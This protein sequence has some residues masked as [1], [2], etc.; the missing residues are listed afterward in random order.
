MCPTLGRTLSAS[1]CLAVPAGERRRVVLGGR[2][3]ALGGHSQA[4]EQLLGLHA[5]CFGKAEA[6]GPVRLA[7]LAVDAV[8]LELGPDSLEVTC[9]AFATAL[10]ASRLDLPLRAAGDR[11]PDE[12]RPEDLVGQMI[13]AASAA[14]ICCDPAE[15]LM[16]PLRLPAA[17]SGGAP[18]GRDP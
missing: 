7:R 14:R 8:R 3:V 10:G 13:A 16:P 9:A 1:A 17:P 12:P 15:E 4:V 2:L 5:L 18:S 6:A 11:P